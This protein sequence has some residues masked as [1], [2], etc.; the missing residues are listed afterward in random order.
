M[1]SISDSYAPLLD[2]HLEDTQIS[3]KETSRTPQK[4]TSNP[5][6]DPPCTKS[7]KKKNRSSIKLDPN[8]HE[9]EEE[10]EEEEDLKVTF[11]LP[12][13]EENVFNNENRSSITA[14]ESDAPPP[15]TEESDVLLAPVLNESE[16]TSEEIASENDN[17]EAPN[18]YLKMAKIVLYIILVLGI[19]Y[20][21]Q[22]VCLHVFKVDAVE[23]LSNKVTNVWT[24]FTSS[25]SVG[26]KDTVLQEASDALHASSSTATPA[27]SP[28]LVMF[29]VSSSGVVTPSILSVPPSVN[30]NVPP[31]SIN[32]VNMKIVPSID[33]S[34]SLLSGNAS[35]N[36]RVMSETVAN[37]L[38]KLLSDM[39]QSSAQ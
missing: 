3:S 36:K 25:N 17:A 19:L 30:V 7:R 4:K 1:A 14:E 5:L 27:V 22:W 31:S 8:E 32:N 38:Q 9:E 34:A 12:S 33:D 2:Q 29:P 23:L 18:K 10:E 35:E 11:N 20:L 21:V 15:A 16:N 28:P 13:S 37:S 39:N 26:I 24:K 6:K